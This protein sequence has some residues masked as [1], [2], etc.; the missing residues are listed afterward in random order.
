[1]S[2]TLTYSDTTEGFE[3]ALC[4]GVTIEE[5]KGEDKREW[6]RSSVRDALVGREQSFRE[7]VSQVEAYRSLPKDWDTYGGLPAS[8]SSV[9]FA[10]N[11]LE[12][13]R[14]LPEVLSPY[15]CPISTG[16]FLEWRSGQSN[17]YFEIDA[18]S[19]LFV[20]REGELVIERGDDPDLNVS[21]A[22]EVVRRF[23]RSAV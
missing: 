18:D 21:R 3:E 16:V 1:M 12:E 20:R 5:R 15:V 7:C 13:L 11:L 10:K 6:L 23:H 19:V 8:D 4:G 14:W 9:R 2:P 22:V 17:L